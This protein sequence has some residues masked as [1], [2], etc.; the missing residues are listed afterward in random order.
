MLSDRE[1]KLLRILWN[2]NQLE[3]VKIDFALICRLTGWTENEVNL[4]IDRL[5]EEKYVERDE[6]DH[7]IRVIEAWDRTQS[8][9]W[10]SWNYR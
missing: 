3:W 5:I 2:L 1:R 10:K 9:E 8:K 6:G 7:F 4:Q